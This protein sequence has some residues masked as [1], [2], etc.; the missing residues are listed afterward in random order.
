LADE[1]KS[2]KLQACQEFIRS[3]HDDDEDEMRPDVS[4]KVPKPK[5]KAGNDAHKA[6]EDTTY[7][8][9]KRK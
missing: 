2:L 7:F 8:H 1:Q 5:D 3:V 4:S 9:F 6:L